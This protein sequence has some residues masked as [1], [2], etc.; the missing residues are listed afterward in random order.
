MP[1]VEQTDE[2]CLTG[3][4]LKAFL[5]LEDDSEDLDAFLAVDERDDIQFTEE[6]VKCTGDIGMQKVL[7]VV[8]S[9][10]SEGPELHVTE[11]RREESPLKIFDIDFSHFELRL[12]KRKVTST[13]RAVFS[14]PTNH[15]MV[16]WNGKCYKWPIRSFQKNDC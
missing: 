4:R 5:T 3:S 7:T 13:C 6:S 2:T 1:S 8:Y 14:L 15:F 12:C 16:W 10:G 11:C 9:K